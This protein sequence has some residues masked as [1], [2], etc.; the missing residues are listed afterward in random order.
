ML[1][2]LLTAVLLMSWTCS[3]I[4]VLNDSDLPKLMKMFQ[5]EQKLSRKLEAADS[6]TDESPA[7]ENH[8]E[9][10]SHHDE[11]QSDD[12][13]ALICE[14]KDE[15]R[16]GLKMEGK[17]MMMKPKELIDCQS[18]IEYPVSKEADLGGDLTDCKGLEYNY[19]KDGE[20]KTTNLYPVRNKD[21]ENEIIAVDGGYYSSLTN[22]T[23][24][25]MFGTVYN[26][27]PWMGDMVVLCMK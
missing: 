9:D 2:K 5:Q 20:D 26:Y 4:Y 18:P 23:I 7:D 8:S 17:D 25:V 6:G 27:R 21:P 3:K 11:E 13:T 24:V 15:A 22:R 12:H 14:Y 16:L 19:K 10:S 1:R